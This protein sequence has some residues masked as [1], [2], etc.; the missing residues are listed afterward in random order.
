V[1]VDDSGRAVV[2]VT[3]SDM[4][5]LFKSA[6]VADHVLSISATAPGLEAYAFTFG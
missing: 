1:H 6:T 3:A 4:Y 2:T 5:R